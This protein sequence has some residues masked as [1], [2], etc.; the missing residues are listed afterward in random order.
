MKKRVLLVLC[1]LV[2]LLS[3]AACGTTTE[4]MYGNY[5][6]TQIESAMESQVNSL[7]G[8]SSEELQQYLAAYKSQ[9][10]S[11]DD[12]N[13]ALYASIYESWSECRP[14]AGDFVGFS[15]FDISK[16]GK[17]VTATLN[18]DY[19]KRDM[20][21]VYV[22]NANDMKIT[23]VNAQLVYSLGETMGKAGL[24]TIMGISIVFV[25]L[26][27]LSLLIY[28]FRF[29]SKVETRVVKNKREEMKP[30]VKAVEPVSED[31]MDDT[32]LI[33]VIAAAIAASTGAS[34]DDFVVRSIKRRY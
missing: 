26:L 19:S 18:I 9:A 22:F 3:F 28:C 12:E 1:A 14:E 11:S 5:T 34:T 23:A 8:L 27:I 33:A 13:Y 16:S 20:Q 29:V 4:E 2:C 7:E 24:N 30:Q 15:D 10:E 17:T 6:G 25:I 21:L 32:E 31:E